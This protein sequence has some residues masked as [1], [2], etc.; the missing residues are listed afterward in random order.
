MLHKD[1]VNVA[2]LVQSPLS[3]FSG[4]G[5]VGSR[6][7]DARAI[8]EILRLASPDGYAMDWDWAK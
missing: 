2:N 6:K 3:I 5:G 1:L 7:D 4:I 8:L